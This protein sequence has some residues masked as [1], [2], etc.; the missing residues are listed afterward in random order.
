[1]TARLRSLDLEPSDGELVCRIRSGETRLFE[2]LM[3]RYNQ[4]LF[5]ARRIA[6]LG[7][8]E[9]LLDAQADALG[10]TCWKARIPWPCSNAIY[11]EE[12]LRALREAQREGITHLVFTDLLPRS[13]HDP[14]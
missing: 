6:M 12:I 11:E 13:A 3:R 9:T 5:P 10:L 7:V 8:R 4:R 2:E 1:M 14:G